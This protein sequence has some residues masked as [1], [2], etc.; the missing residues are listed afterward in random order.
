MADPKPPIRTQLTWRHDL[1][2]SA[3]AGTARLALDGD[4]AAGLSPMQA[5]ALGL[6]GCMAADLVHIL[7]RGRHPL[8][9][10]SARLDG[11]RA[12]GQ[13]AR[14]TRMALHYVVSGGVPLEAI[15]RAIQ[16]SRDKYCSVW[17][18]LRQD[19]QLDV[20]FEVTSANA[21]GRVRED[22]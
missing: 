18:S 15:E 21:D 17:H 9:G 14:F 16:L 10:L 19:I 12:E 3:E 2:F 4:G 13:P 5:V 11:H 20:T 8:K 7:T 1:V 6:A 22:A